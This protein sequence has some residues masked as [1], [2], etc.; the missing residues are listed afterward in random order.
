MYSAPITRHNKAAFVILMDRSGSMAEEVT[1]QGCKTTKAEALADAVN[2]LLEE[3]INHS[4]RERHI[5]D[6]F[7][8]AI[9]GYGDKGVESLLGS[10]F[11]SIV[12]ID[13]MD[14]PSY[15][16]L[17]SHT[18]P[19]GKRC[20]TIVKLRRWIT[21]QASGQTPMGEALR[22][23]RRLIASWCKRHPSSF[24]P[25][26]INISD[27]EATDACEQEIR[28][29]AEQ[30]KSVATNDG[31]ALLMNIHLASLH[32]SESAPLCFPAENSPLPIN[33][34]SRLLYDISSTLPPL[35]N[36]H[37]LASHNEMPPF[38]AICYNAPIND[39]VSLLAIGSLSINQLF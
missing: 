16:K 21:P 19:S 17:K 18:L 33:R 35:Y 38:R 3:I 26:I 8:V 5:G 11:R 37:L 10:G 14:V 4:R 1:F 9:L 36:T 27:G 25:I 24:P 12:D 34:H 28:A 13:T 32:D 2:T 20:D 6:Y 15:A 29:L 7:D 22:I 39:I 31:G 30:I 23:T